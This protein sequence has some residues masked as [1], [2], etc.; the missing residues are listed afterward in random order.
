MRQVLAASL[1]AVAQSQSSLVASGLES[2]VKE[3][4]CGDLTLTLSTFAETLRVQYIK[5]YESEQYCADGLVNQ[6]VVANNLDVTNTDAFIL[7]S[8]HPAVT[9]TDGQTL[10]VDLSIA[11]FA[12]CQVER[13]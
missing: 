3:G 13:K 5:V 12:N 4:H 2:I 11:N 8:D 9:A 7:N 1:F 10:T 6:Q